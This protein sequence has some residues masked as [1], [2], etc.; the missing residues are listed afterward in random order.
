MA[1][2]DLTAI[3]LNGA[4]RPT[5]RGMTE[6]S[7]AEVQA[8][9]DRKVGWAPES[10]RE[11]VNGGTQ[12]SMSMQPGCPVVADHASEIGWRCVNLEAGATDQR[13]VMPFG[14]GRRSEAPPTSL[15]TKTSGRRRAR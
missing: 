6:G 5:G 14:A 13:R 9:A 15:T 2:S 4:H 10:K 12:D 1:M 3:P 8:A 7:D 11:R